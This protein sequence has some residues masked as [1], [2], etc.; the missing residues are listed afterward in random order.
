MGINFAGKDKYRTLLKRVSL[1]SIGG[2]LALNLSGCY[3]LPKEEEVLAP[4]LV[5]TPKLTFSTIEVKR[6]N[7]EK[8]ITV[9]GALT[10]SHLENVFFKFR[11]GTL[12]SINVSLGDN[13]KKGQLLAELDTD[14]LVTQIKQQEINVE[15]NQLRYDS[16]KENENSSKYDIEEARLNLESAKLRLQELKRDYEKAKLHSTISG[17]VVYLDSV[18]SGD[19][20][21]ANKTLITV[22]DPSKLIVQ[23]RGD[24]SSTFQQGAKVDL[25]YRGNMYKGEVIASP[26]TVPLD[27]HKNLR[28]AVYFKIE[29][30][31]KD[32]RIGETVDITLILDRKEDVIII[33]RSLV[34]NYS[35]RSYVQILEN[36]MRYERDVEIGLQTPTEVEIVKGLKEGDQLIQR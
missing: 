25:R 8:K 31:P 26:F 12:K 7:I 1:I 17:Y 6:G 21:N 20:V 4:P 29:G 16:R 27:A 5:S 36:D 22:A 19:Y 35:G 32:A 14:N 24:D 23:Y 30:L 28:T 2:L 13:V 9:S 11:G 18:N 15:I 34:N 33:P 3:F 10:S